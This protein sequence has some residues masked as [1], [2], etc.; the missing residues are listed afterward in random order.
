MV[1]KWLKGATARD[2][3]KTSRRSQAGKSWEASRKKRSGSCS[4]NSTTSGRTTPRQFASSHL[5]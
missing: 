3:P 1:T 2:V 5:K 4:P